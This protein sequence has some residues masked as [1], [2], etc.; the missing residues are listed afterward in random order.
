VQL[1]NL[2]A[3]LVYKYGSVRFVHDAARIAE[4]GGTASLRE[5]RHRHIWKN[6]SYQQALAI[7]DIHRRRQSRD[8]N[9]LIPIE[10]NASD[11]GSLGGLDLQSTGTD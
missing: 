10:A 9:F 2:V 3:S 8:Q 4:S 7:P 11:R 1:K 6:P 5:E